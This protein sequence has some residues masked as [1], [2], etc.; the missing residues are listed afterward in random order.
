MEKWKVLTKLRKKDTTSE[1][2]LSTSQD[3]LAT[4]QDVPTTSQDALATSQD[5]PSTSLNFQTKVQ[6]SKPGTGIE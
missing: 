3:V 2:V 6:T 4:S 1:D 5:D